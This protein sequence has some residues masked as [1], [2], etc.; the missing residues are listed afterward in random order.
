[1]PPSP[2]KPQQKDNGARETP[3]DGAGGASLLGGQ[4]ALVQGFRSRPSLPGLG[5]VGS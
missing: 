2:T 5:E 3:G 4:G 1:M